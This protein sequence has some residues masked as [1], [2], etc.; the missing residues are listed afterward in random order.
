MEILTNYN[1]KEPS[2]RGNWFIGKVEKVSS[3]VVMATLFFGP[4]L[5]PVPDC[6]LRFPDEI[7]RLVAP[8]KVVERTEQQEK[9]MR[10]PVSRKNPPKCEVCQDIH[11]KK[12]KECGGKEDPDT[13]IICD[14]CESFFHVKCVGC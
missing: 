3:E 13:L 10:I 12:C 6:E 11:K 7:M 4:D 5:A 1:M 2:K 14:E 8:L 9:D